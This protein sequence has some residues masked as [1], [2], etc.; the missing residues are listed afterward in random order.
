M[1]VL[2]EQ[3]IKATITE[4]IERGK[5]ILE[6]MSQLPP[7]V[8]QTAQSFDALH[9]INGAMIDQ[10][11]RNLKNSTPGAMPGAVTPGTGKS[12]A[13]VPAGTNQPAPSALPPTQSAPSALPAIKPGTTRMLNTQTNKLAD[14]PNNVLNTDAK[15]LKDQGYV[16]YQGK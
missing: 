13:G 2:N 5:N 9:A 1:E 6:K 11:S 15:K 12:P 4:R 8:I 14:I 3:E 16:I 7:N 10:A